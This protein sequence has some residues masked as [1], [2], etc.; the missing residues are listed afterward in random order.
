M[1]CQRL[2]TYTYKM[3]MLPVAKLSICFYS[4]TVTQVP[5]G[6]SGRSPELFCHNK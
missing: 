2:F 3:V 5:S 1:R 6:Q 4:I